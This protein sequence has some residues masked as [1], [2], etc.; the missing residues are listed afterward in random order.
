[1]NQEVVK[2]L[3]QLAEKA[4]TTVERLWPL[5]VRALV[6]DAISDVV[7]GLLLLALSGVMYRTTMKFAKRAE[8]YDSMSTERLNWTVYSIIGVVF[9][10]IVFISA[11]A[12]ISSLPVLLEPE[13][14]MVRDL[15]GK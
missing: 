9:A 4:G 14:F 13:G 3:E 15:L 6:V 12:N 8:D 1:M 11:L 7:W 10:V 2:L 5:A